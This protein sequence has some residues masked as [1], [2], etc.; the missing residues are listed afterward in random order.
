MRYYISD[1]HFFHDD[2]N[3][4]M[5]KRGFESAEAM[6]EYMIERW[7]N[8]VNKGDEVVI[9]GDFSFGKADQT[10]EL[11]NRLKGKK[12]MIEGNHDRFLSDKKFDLSLFKWVKDYAEVKDDKRRVILS[13]YPVFC[14]KG[15]FHKD[16]DG[17]PKTYMLYGHVHNTFDEVLLNKFIDI[18]RNAV[19][20]GFDDPEE[21]RI[22]CQMINCF[23]MFSDYTPLTLDEWIENDA[24]RRAAMPKEFDQ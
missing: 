15:Q 2:M 6:N 11:L 3:K 21:G 9:L 16:K 22:P 23:C 12:Y 10:I 20:P 17:N 18:T 8:K 5:D 7:N 24:K 14:Y 4:N 19:R 1:L 13:H